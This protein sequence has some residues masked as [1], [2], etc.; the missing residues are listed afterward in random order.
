MAVLAAAIIGGVVSAGGALIKG[1]MQGKAAE[2]QAQAAK[3]AASRYA[4]ALKMEAS[5]IQGGIS[6]AL[7][8]TL[9]AGGALQRASEAQ[10]TRDD[11]ARGGRGPTSDQ[12]MALAAAQQVGA[13]QQQQGVDAS[14]SQVA[15]QKAAQRSNLQLQALQSEAQAQ[16]IDPAAAKKMR[17]AEGIGAALGAAGQTA[18]S[19]TGAAAI[20]KIAAADLSK[21]YQGLAGVDMTNFDPKQTLDAAQTRAYGT[22]QAYQ[23]RN[24]VI[25]PY[26]TQ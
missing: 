25:P 16:A 20:E 19:L 8:D 24:P 4:K 1:Q 12:E 5:K 26:P 23:A 7:K 14:S 9:M 15:M 21:A 11:I 18:V 2:S 10:Q 13:A 17:T 3:T 6:S 22:I